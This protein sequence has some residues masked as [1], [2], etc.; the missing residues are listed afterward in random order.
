M[1]KCNL[2]QKNDAVIVQSFDYD[3]IEKKIGY[4]HKCM[5]DIVKYH[6]SPVNTKILKI[7]NTNVFFR[8]IFTFKKENIELKN[9]RGRVLIELPISIKKMLFVDDDNS[10]LRDTQA[11]IKRGLDYWQNEYRKALEEFDEE[12]LK[13]IE[14]IIKKLKKLL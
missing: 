13:A 14:N 12:K 7:Y 1:M 8:N 10:A 9:I 4:C 6:I 2:C 3:G 5:K 11:I